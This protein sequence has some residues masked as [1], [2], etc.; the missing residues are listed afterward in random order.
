MSEL[1]Q[2]E[3]QQEEVRE[4]SEQDTLKLGVSR[5]TFIGTGMT[6][7]AAA[8][9]LPRQAIADDP[10]DDPNNDSDLDPP[11]G[12]DFMQPEFIV[13]EP[14][15]D[16][17]SII[18]LSAT[19]V[20]AAN[21]DITRRFCYNGK[22]MF[23]GPTF[24]VSPGSELNI[25][26]T[27]ELPDNAPGGPKVNT[28][29]LHFH[30][31]HVSPLS[32][33]GVSGNDAD[34]SPPGQSSD[35]VLVELEPNSLDPI[36]H[37]YNVHIPEYH[38]PGTHWYHPHV[39]GSTAV[40]VVN[41]MAGAIIIEEPPGERL[42]PEERDFV[43]VIQDIETGTHIYDQGL[44][45]GERKTLEIMVNG[46][47]EPILSISSNTMY[48]LR[49]INATALPSGFITLKFMN[50][51]EDDS[52]IHSRKIEE[53]TDTAQCHGVYRVAVDGISHYNMPPEPVD[54]EGWD[55]SPGNR[56]D[57]LVMLDEGRYKVEIQLDRSKGKLP[58]N[59]DVDR[60]GTLASICVMEGPDAPEPE[61][62]FPEI[63]PL[64]TNLSNSYDSGTHYLSPFRSNVDI[65]KDQT[66]T[67]SKSKPNALINNE[68]YGPDTLE[69]NVPI[70]TEEI[71]EL[72]HGGGGSAHPFHIHVNPFQV[73]EIEGDS[74]HDYKNI[75]FDTF[76][77]QERQPVKIRHRF[78]DYVGKFVFHCHI[79]LHEDRGMMRNIN[80]TGC[81]KGPGSNGGMINWPDNGTQ[82]DSCPDSVEL[83]T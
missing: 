42:V 21:G 5:R 38:A 47:K 56:A 49:F 51:D 34:G 61:C 48:R 30:G 53:S 4:N 74:N 9:V 81:G 22:K 67:F 27:N 62:I 37:T 12:Q 63:I 54:P 35:D 55:M 24:R 75:W 29:N 82:A 66:V 1:N 52:P 2:E 3:Q 72:C 7:A 69:F 77:V 64:H 41:G 57:F 10:C 19:C 70:D 39:H 45:G 16:S 76:F 15:P 32:Y 17:P 13:V 59:G 71:W 78:K 20:P 58:Q 6:A 65:D 43:F 26:Y 18:N 60:F 14:E 8:L 28:T 50:E 33:G 44:S 46:Q 11:P 23:P 40:Q 25:K 36:T 73:I 83:S 79:L 31:L 68:A 80:V